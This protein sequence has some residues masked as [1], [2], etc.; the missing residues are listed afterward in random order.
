MI[1]Y[2]MLSY[3]I[4]CYNMLLY[5]IICYYM[6]LYVHVLICYYMLLDWII[7]CDFRPALFLWIYSTTC[8]KMATAMATA[9]AQPFGGIFDP[10]K[11]HGARGRLRQA[12]HAMGRWGDVLSHGSAMAVCQAGEDRER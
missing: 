10:C 7:F 8:A 9:M 6:L 11:D 4:I 1:C 2:H 3:V 5:V 12:R